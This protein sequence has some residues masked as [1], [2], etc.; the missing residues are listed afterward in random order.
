MSARKWTEEQKARQAALIH[1]WNP[2]EQSSGA[3][4][5]EGKRISS[6]NAFR[7]TQR[8]AL[9]YACWLLKESKKCRAGKPYASIDEVMLAGARRGLI[10]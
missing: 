8:K 3:R 4:T 9:I 5:P 10:D 7:F 1:K 6:R 2:W